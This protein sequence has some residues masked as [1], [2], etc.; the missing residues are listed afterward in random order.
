[1]L[2]PTLVA[3]AEKKKAAAA[4]A[5]AAAGDGSSSGG[6]SSDN[7]SGGSGTSGGCVTGGGGGGGNGGGA[8]GVPSL[9]ALERFAFFGMFDGHG[10]AGCSHLLQQ[11][12]HVALAS[13]RRFA[14]HPSEAC[15]A[16]FSQVN[17]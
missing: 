8:S 15:A 14:S 11:R 10:G 17:E 16:V 9:A 3:N 5:A 1:M 13:H 7:S 12:L 2:R 4:A 6:S